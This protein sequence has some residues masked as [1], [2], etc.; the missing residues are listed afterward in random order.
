MRNS[1]QNCYDDGWKGRIVDEAFAHPAKMAYGLLKRILAHAAAEGWLKPGHI[2]VDPFGGIGSTGILGAYEGYQVVCCELEQRFVDLARQNFELHAKALEALGCP[3]PQIIQ[4]DS[5][6]LCGVVADCIVSSP[7]FQKAQTGGGIAKKGYHN[8]AMRRGVFDLVGKRAYM[9]ENQGTADGNLAAMP[10]GEVDAVI[11][12][13]PYA[14]TLKGDGTQSETAAESRDKRRTEGGSLGQSQR[15][16]GYGSDGNL[17]NLKA[18][19]VDAVVS[20]PPFS[21]P[22]SQ[23]AGNMPSTPIRSKIRKMGL[24][25]KA[26]EEY[27]RTPGN[28]GNLKPGDV[29]MICSSPPWENQEPCQDDN[30]RLSDGRKAPPQGQ[31]GYGQ[32]EGNIG[33]DKGETFWQAARQIV[34]QCREILKPGGVAIWVV[35][36]FVRNKKI[37]DFTG[38]WRRLCE[39]CGFEAL[40]EHHAMLVKETK[41]AGLFGE[42]VEKKERKSFFRRLAESKGS[43]PIDYETVLCMRTAAPPIT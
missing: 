39:S 21:S 43:P 40:H 23:P 3:Q 13:P 4:G 32:T 30:F 10:P 9:P 22:G 20:S 29:D 16:Q 19:S 24:E 25:K 5:R 38:D 35:K 33:N 12:S 17:G 11:G 31:G 26:G 27:G 42:I 36:N 7:P 34:Q 8:E 41:E 37:V 28:L 6:R 18:G 1:W 14:E 15:T 2:I